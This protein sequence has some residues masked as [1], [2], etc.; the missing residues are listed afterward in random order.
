MG[1]QAIS[2]L[3]ALTQMLTN[4]RDL[5]ATELDSANPL[6]AEL[7]QAV[8]NS[9]SLGDY[10]ANSLSGYAETRMALGNVGFE[11]APWPGGGSYGSRR[12]ADLTRNMSQIG[13]IGNVARPKENDLRTNG[14]QY[15]DTDQ[16][17]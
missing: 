13:Q 16:L 14:G 8:S 7:N 3:Q 1:G 5:L 17:T 12:L 9:R 11:V 15:S 2:Q 6:L 10:Y 4:I